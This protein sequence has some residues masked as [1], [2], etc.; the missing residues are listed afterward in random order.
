MEKKLT[1]RKKIKLE[2]K[3]VSNL[4]ASIFNQKGEISGSKFLPDEIF[5]QKIN[6]K[7]LSQAV[8][9]YQGNKCVQSVGTKTR[10]E[11][12]GGGK[13]PWKQ[14][15]TGRARQGSIRAPHWRGGGIVFGPKPRNISFALT[16]KMKNKAFYTAL[17]YK[18]SQQKIQLLFLN[19]NIE[20]TKQ[21]DQL[22]QKI[23]ENKPMKNILLVV[24]E[25]DQTVG[26]KNLDYV[27]IVRVNTLNT[28]E[29]LRHDQLLLT[30]NSMEKIY[31]FK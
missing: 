20:K 18:A 24:G 22:L 12:S 14:K 29:V 4:S 17:S 23:Y 1:T 31:G 11:V 8:R 3:I 9:V 30:Q 5:G 21:A 13:K 15:G 2:K 6:V 16:H 26:F 27:D 28:L 19:E 25:K 10:G 7:L